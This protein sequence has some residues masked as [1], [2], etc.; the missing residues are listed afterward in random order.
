MLSFERTQ[1][2]SKNRYQRNALCEAFWFGQLCMNTRQILIKKSQRRPCRRWQ[3]VYLGCPDS[4]VHGANMGPIWDRQ[5]PGG[6]HVGPMNFA[7]WVCTVQT[8]LSLK[9][10]LYCNLSI[11]V[12]SHECFGVSNHRQQ[13]TKPNSKANT[14]A[15]QY[16]PCVRRI[17]RSVGSPHKG[18][19]MWRAFPSHDVVMCTLKPGA[20]FNIKMSSYQYRKSLCGDRRSWDRLISTMGFPILVRWHLYFESGPCLFWKHNCRIHCSY[21][22]VIHTIHDMIL[23]YVFCVDLSRI[24]AGLWWPSMEMLSALLVICEENHRSLVDSYHKG[25]ML[26]AALWCFLCCYVEQ[27]V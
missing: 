27:V 25:P 24:Y 1:L 2:N 18:P 22:Y 13:L 9:L 10:I 5:D 7:I 16:W 4:E 3:S 6:P 23:K 12:T 17:R 14:K 11:T 20:W 26:L 19:V 8:V 15:P 21:V